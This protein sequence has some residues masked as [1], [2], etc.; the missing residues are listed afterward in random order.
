MVEYIC[1]KAGCAVERYDAAV[2]MLL[3]SRKSPRGGLLLGFRRGVG[4]V[5]VLAVA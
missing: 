5:V 1:K 4:V 2:F 3:S